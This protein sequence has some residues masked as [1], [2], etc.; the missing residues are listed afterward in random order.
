[1]NT[2]IKQAHESDA[3]PIAVWL[4]LAMLTMGVVA[5]DLSGYDR[6]VMQWFGEA[7]GF[8]L[9]HDDWLENVLHDGARRVA[10]TVYFI[11]VVS[12]KWPW[13]PFKRLTAAQRVEAVSGVLLALLLVNLIKRGSL[14]SCPWELQSFGGTATY[15][16]HW[17]WGV[18]DGGTGRCFPGG[19]ASAGFAF[20]AFVWLWWRRDEVRD[21]RL[22]Q[23]IFVVV[24]VVG[25]VLGRV[26]TLRGAH[27]PS[28]TLWTA[29]ICWVTT[30]VWHQ[31]WTHC[32]F[33]GHRQPKGRSRPV[34]GK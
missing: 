23:R 19:H 16:S 18:S 1:M 10:W 34:V 33:L 28:H 2:Q 9:R 20:L 31:V 13:G 25:F 30:W 22:A 6:G 32:R 14:T 17:L 29:W 21:Q 27:Y 15:V 5:W 11:A 12:A 7:T 4:G 24:M 26:Q 8:G 3:R